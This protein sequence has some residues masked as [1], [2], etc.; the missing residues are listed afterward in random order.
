MNDKTT[1]T[2]LSIN[3]KGRLLDFRRP[4]VMGIVNVTP[5]SFFSGSRTFTPATIEERVSRLINEGADILDVGAYST[6]PGADDVSPAEE[7]RRLDE[8]LGIIRD[9]FPDA[10][11]SID[12]FRADVARDCIEKWGA[13]IIND[14]SGGTLDSE[15]WQTVAELDVPYVLMHM[16]GNPASMQSM[17]EYA[18]VTAD[19]ISDL[20]FKLDRLRLLGVKDVIIDPGFGFAKT[21]DQNFSLLASLDKFKELGC[22]VLAGLSRKSMIWK[23]L[24][25]IPEESL[26]GTIAL[27]MAALLNGA[28]ILRVHDVKAAVET[29]ELYSLLK[30]NSINPF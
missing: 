21:I 3:I 23:S 24:S 12:T 15:L 10:V 25:I 29:R 14:I 2:P 11:I 5:D 22:P 6:R 30:K 19:V 1:A 27:N 8:G 17:T 28:S 26:G 20:A 18:D 13:D 4:L 7:W 16:R 9:K